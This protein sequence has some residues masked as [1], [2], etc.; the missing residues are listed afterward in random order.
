MRSRLWEAPGILCLPRCFLLHALLT[1]YSMRVWMAYLPYTC[2]GR[3]ASHPTSF[4]GPCRHA[5]RACR[6]PTRAVVT[7]RPTSHRLR[8]T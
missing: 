4:R 2:K 8:D 3:F 7:W 5:S 1:F 6:S